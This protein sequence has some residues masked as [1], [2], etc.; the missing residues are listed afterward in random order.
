[1]RVYSKEKC[2]LLIVIK[3]N[4]LKLIY[5][6]CNHRKSIWINI[7]DGIF[8]IKMHARVIY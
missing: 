2:I 6:I 4:S 1:M 7:D 3:L 8:Q 5:L